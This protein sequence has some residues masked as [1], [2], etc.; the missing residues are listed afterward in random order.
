MVGSHMEEAVEAMAMELYRTAMGERHSSLLLN[1][2]GEWSWESRDDRVKGSWRIVARRL[3]KGSVRPHIEAELR[4]RL[5]E[6]FERIGG[7]P[8]P[9]EDREDFAER[10]ECG[11][12]LRI[13]YEVGQA[14]LKQEGEIR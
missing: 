12:A 4:E 10:V 3:L 5:T 2:E 9:G 6:P 1:P 7:L 14:L 8:A 13:A 11:D